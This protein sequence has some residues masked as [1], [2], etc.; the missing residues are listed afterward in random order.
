MRT[1]L[2]I[3]ALAIPRTA[4]QPLGPT[5]NLPTSPAPALPWSKGPRRQRFTSQAPAAPATLTAAARASYL[6]S[7]PT[8]DGTIPDEAKTVLVQIGDWP[9]VTALP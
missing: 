5:R 9:R 7:G 6:P 1:L 3:L 2:L 8:S 4:Q